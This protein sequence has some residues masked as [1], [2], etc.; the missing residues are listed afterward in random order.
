MNTREKRNW[1]RE[2]R[3]LAYLVVLLLASARLKA[4]TTGYKEDRD[5]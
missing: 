4:R 3:P 1:L 2:F 5:E